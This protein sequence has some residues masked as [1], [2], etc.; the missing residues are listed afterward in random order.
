[1]LRLS[2][3]KYVCATVIYEVTASRNIYY[4]DNFIKIIIHLPFII[5]A[6]Q[7]MGILLGQNVATCLYSRFTSKTKKLGNLKESSARIQY[8][9]RRGSET[10][11]CYTVD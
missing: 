10:R 5:H 7:M 3:S 9:L 1:M 8:W 6:K 4:A 2:K 11:L